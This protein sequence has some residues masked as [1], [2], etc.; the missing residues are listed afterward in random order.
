MNLNLEGKTSKLAWGLGILGTLLFISA[1]VYWISLT[2]EDSIKQQE[3]QLISRLKEKKD[4][5]IRSFRRNK[6][7]F[8]HMGL[9]NF[10]DKKTED[11][12]GA[13]A[14]SIWCD[15]NLRRKR[16]FI[17]LDGYH[18][19]CTLSMGDVLWLNKKSENLINLDKFP[20][21]LETFQYQLFPYF[22][23]SWD[24][25]DWMRNYRTWKNWCEWK[26][27]EPYSYKNKY[28]KD[29]IQRFCF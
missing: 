3:F 5:Y 14:L 18:R 11:E 17:N 6:G 28:K 13:V 8:I 22:K 15:S 4:L 25:I 19:L 24:S 29:A 21:N 2:V 23:L 12:E 20:S 26:L 1:S 27:S 10:T 7:I 9:H 16:H